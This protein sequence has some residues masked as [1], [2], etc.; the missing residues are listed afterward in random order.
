MRCP[1]TISLAYT[2]THINKSSYVKTKRYIN[3]FTYQTSYKNT[4]PDTIPDY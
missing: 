2:K 1:Q 3:T 4:Y